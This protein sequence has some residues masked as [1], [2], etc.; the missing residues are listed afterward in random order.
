MSSSSLDFSE[1]KL[2]PIST[3]KLELNDEDDQS[4]QKSAKKIC[5]DK[6]EAFA[7]CLVRMRV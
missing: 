6:V 5:D 7:H 2:D 4:D 1:L 3:E